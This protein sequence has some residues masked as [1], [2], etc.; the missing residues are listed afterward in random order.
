MS[1]LNVALSNNEQVAF[2]LSDTAAYRPK[3]GIVIGFTSKVRAFPHASAAFGGRGAVNTLTYIG[4]MLQYCRDFDEMA[5]VLERRFANGLPAKAH[6][7]FVAIEGLFRRSRKGQSQRVTSGAVEINLVGYS[8]KAKKMV[9]LSSVTCGPQ[10]FELQSAPILLGPPL[11]LEEIDAIRWP[12][13]RQYMADKLV[14]GKKLLEIMK[15][16]R[17]VSIE[18][19]GGEVIGGVA[20]LTTILP[21]GI[22]QQIMHRWDDKVGEVIA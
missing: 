16:Q 20:V 15:R 9:L 4:N 10:A 18:R 11:P 22:S 12:D 7:L 1:A 17:E 13:D 8:E 19:P 3:N 5:E 14:W 6:R 2:I 21:Q